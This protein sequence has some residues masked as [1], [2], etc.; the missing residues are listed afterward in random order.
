MYSFATHPRTTIVK[1]LITTCIF[2]LSSS[3]SSITSADDLSEAAATQIE[4]GSLTGVTTDGLAIFKGIPFAA[5][6]VGDLRWRAPEPAASWEGVR[7]ANHFA[8]ACMQLDNPMIDV[9]KVGVSEDCLYLNV[10]TPAENKEDKLPVVVWIHGGGFSF[11]A[12]SQ[13]L[14]DGSHLARE[15]VVFVSLTYRLGPL[16]FLAHP[17]LSAESSQGTSGN[18]AILDQIAGLQWVN[19]NIAAF[20]GDP[21]RVTIMGESAGAFSVSI[22]AASPLAKG[23]FHQVIAESGASFEIASDDAH[24][25]QNLMTLAAAETLGKEWA[26]K[27]G[28]STTAQM[29]AMDA[30]ALLKSFKRQSLFVL[31]SG[32]PTLD[33]YVIADNAIDLY[34]AGKQ[35]D[36]PILVGWNEDEGSLFV[37]KRSLEEHNAYVKQHFGDHLEQIFAAYPADNEKQ[38]LEASQDIFRDKSFGW[39]VWKWAELQSRHGEGTTYLYHFNQFPPAA[40]G[41]PSYGAAHALD[42]FYVFKNLMPIMN[43]TGADRAISAA[44]SSYWINF[45]KTGNP[46]G[47][48]LPR[49]QAWNNEKPAAM[50]F[51][52]GVA[53]MRPGIPNEAQI[54]TIDDFVESRRAK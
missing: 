44:M 51:E 33:G 49:W 20:G 14:F 6:P 31:D 34:T 39:P 15:G 26:N 2:T 19:R 18:Y 48:S 50:Y 22:L 1:G 30:E 54:R 43:W 12:S 10:W 9:S 16:G 46:N 38:A 32:W 17:D 25:D 41:K 11:G 35:N 45:I 5:P 40:P 29:R 36:T 7:D 21:E 47:A 52:N 3:L 8:P 42:M 23:L 37:Q 27:Q 24:D 53:S 28:L 4:S 13:A